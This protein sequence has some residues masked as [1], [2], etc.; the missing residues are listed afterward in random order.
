[1]PEIQKGRGGPTA[2]VG[3]SAHVNYF[4]RDIVHLIQKFVDAAERRVLIDISSF[5]NTNRSDQF[6]R[7]VYGEDQVTAPA[8]RGLME[9][10]WDMGILPDVEVLP[11]PSR[12]DSNPTTRKE[13][14][15][16]AMEGSWVAPKDRAMATQVLESHFEDLFAVEQDAIIP[17]WRPQGQEVLITWEKS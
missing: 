1:M 17:L 2:G 14:I 9:V 6:F 5:A 8:H 3:L 15:E 13:A 16:Q 10:I 7:L 12:T 4:I 11:L